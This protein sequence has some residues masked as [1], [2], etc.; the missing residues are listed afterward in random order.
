MNKCTEQI[1]LAL[2]KQTYCTRWVNEPDDHLANDGNHSTYSEIPGTHRGALARW[3]VT[4]G[5]KY[6][7]RGFFLNAEVEKKSSRGLKFVVTISAG[8][9]FDKTIFVRRK[10]LNGYDDCWVSEMIDTRG[11][12]VKSMTSACDQRNKYRYVAVWVPNTVYLKIRE[13]ELYAS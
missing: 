9:I 7:I 3:I 11:I 1:N 12:I 2:Y 8:N 4:L 13:F 6:S 5:T 10:V